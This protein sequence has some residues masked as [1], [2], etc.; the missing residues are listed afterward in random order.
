MSFENCQLCKNLW[1][2]FLSQIILR[3]LGLFQKWFSR[4]CVPYWIVTVPNTQ[5]TAAIKTKGISAPIFI[6]III[7]LSVD[8]VPLDF[9]LQSIC[10]YYSEI[11]ACYGVAKDS[12]ICILQCL[13][14]FCFGVGLNPILRA[15]GVFSN[16]LHLRLK[17]I[18]YLD[19]NS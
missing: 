7:S 8:W 4:F 12:Q 17:T 14:V 11:I 15:I 18:I 1:N 6:K 16:I 2:F 19:T 5:E 3:L 9:H 10:N 13:E